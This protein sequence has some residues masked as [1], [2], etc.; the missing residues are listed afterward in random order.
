[1]GRTGRRPGT[2]RNCLFLAT[3]DDGLLRAAGLLDLWRS[4]YVE[5]AE[6]PPLPLHIL[7]QQ[8]L[9]LALQERGVGRHEWHGWIAAVPAF[10]ALDPDLVERIIVGMLDRQ[11]LWDESG[12]LWLGRE[13]QDAYGRKN[14]LDL[15]SVFTAPP[16][17]TV[18]HGRRE[19]GFV[20][21]STFLVRREDGPPVLLLAGHAWRVTHLDWKRRKAYV[22]P[23]EDEGRSRWRGGGQFLGRELCRAIRGILAG[24]APAPFWSRRASAR[25]ETLR[26]EHPWLDGREDNILVT[27]GDEL[28]W[29]TFAGGRANA[30]LACTLSRSLDLKVASDNFSVTFGTPP[31]PQA[32][33][34]EVLGLITADAV[35]IVPAVNEAA[36]DGLKFAECLPTDLADRVIQA[37]LADEG[38]VVEVLARPT[39]CV[40]A[41]VP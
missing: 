7:A 35:S 23:A 40:T 26:N 11:V 6:P 31:D 36:R 37:R 4:G 32:V 2:T 9:A 29:W 16:L 27:E 1:M 17:F 12:V 8:I 22:E 39:R 34:R 33:E 10:R 20:D 3:T 25:L 41:D 38:G 13:G 24:D 21:E 14:F 30:A 5:P 18:L 15:I 19:L 28:T